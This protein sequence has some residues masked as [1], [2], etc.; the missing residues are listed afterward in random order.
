ME[1]DLPDLEPWLVSNELLI[2]HPSPGMPSTQGFLGMHVANL[3]KLEESAQTLSRGTD[4]GHE[5][6]K[7]SMEQKRLDSR[8][9][10]IRSIRSNRASLRMSHHSS[11]SHS[12]HASNASSAHLSADTYSAIRWPG[13]DSMGPDSPPVMSIVSQSSGWNQLPSRTS[14][15]S[16]GTA[17]HESSIRTSGGYEHILSPTIRTSSDSAPSSISPPLLATHQ[18]SLVSTMRERDGLGLNTTSFT[19]SSM[20]TPIKVLPVR[21]ESKHLRTIST[22]SSETYHMRTAFGDFDGVHYSPVEEHFGEEDANTGL[23]LEIPTV[24]QPAAN[25]G[26]MPEE[27][28]ER[29]E[30]PV[31]VPRTRST[32]LPADNLVYYP[33]PVPMRLNLPKRLTKPKSPH[34]AMRRTQILNP[35]V[36]RDR[37]SAMWAT[38]S[39]VSDNGQAQQIRNVAQNRQSVLNLEKL[40]P[41]LRATVFFD[42]PSVT[43]NLA[44]KNGSAVETLESMLDAAARAPVAH[45]Y[46][47]L[48]DDSLD[49]TLRPNPLNR[50]STV[51]YLEAQKIR[52]SVLLAKPSDMEKRGE[53]PDSGRLSLADDIGTESA[54][55]VD[56][57]NDEP[58]GEKATKNLT[59]APSLRP[60]EDMA[61]A[62]GDDSEAA[63]SLSDDGGVKVTEQEPVIAPTTLLAELEMRKQQLKSRSRTAATAFPKG[64]HS[65]LLELDAVANVEEKKRKSKRTTL[66]WE[67]PKDAITAAERAVDEEDIPLAVL[68]PADK[69]PGRGQ[70]DWDRPLSLTQK[71]DLGDS[72]LLSSRRD[73][74]REKALPPLPPHV[75]SAES[76]AGFNP[77]DEGETLAQRTRRLKAASDATHLFQPLASGP[78]AL[79]PSK[80]AA[81]E[82]NGLKRASTIRLLPAAASPDPNVGGEEEETLGQRRRRLHAEAGAVVASRK[83]SLEQQAA[84]PD[85]PRRISS[86]ANMFTAHTVPPYQPTPTGKS[87]Q[88][89]G[90]LLGQSIQLQA[91]HKAHILAT[92][93]NLRISSYI[94]SAVAP[95]AT[96]NAGLHG[97]A[98]QTYYIQS[99]QGG[100]VQDNDSGNSPYRGSVMYPDFTSLVP[101]QVRASG[102]PPVAVAVVAGDTTAQRGNIDRWRLSVQS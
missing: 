1:E 92:T 39:P 7:M 37:K 41:H 94:P 38:Q 22:A 33:A 102:K 9:S 13:F 34:E 73:R 14:T 16:G 95:V 86:L 20:S 46:K 44:I 101:T 50:R 59:R 49:S 71:R 5:I 17:R 30:P 99:A 63:D 19:G 8:R 76:I 26:V 29:V 27:R 45:T 58:E 67:D 85:Q 28:V 11:A 18:Q 91:E 97:Q 51:P 90:G 42:D 70:S 77:T 4:L 12:R 64:M 32:P 55:D 54:F 15:S 66:A 88:A 87:Q 82:Q 84:R 52:R 2:E 72:E 62:M 3:E 56:F 93:Q 53:Q 78:R 96:T 60:V 65:T 69:K 36:Y 40:P 89:V 57:G 6:R 74:L 23:G 48:E 80:L 25:I 21:K 47:P 75:L 35:L 31:A 43:H 98:I 81:T 100:Q 61:R 24:Q 68:Y 10:S 79:N 83:A